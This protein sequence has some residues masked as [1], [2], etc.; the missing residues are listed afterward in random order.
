MVNEKKE[1]ELPVSKSIEHD[2]E[3]YDKRI[4]SLLKKINYIQS[5]YFQ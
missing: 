4:K 3:I 1:Y 2:L 5:R